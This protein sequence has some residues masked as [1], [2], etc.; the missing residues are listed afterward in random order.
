MRGDNSRAVS[1]IIPAKTIPQIIPTGMTSTLS[2]SNVYASSP[3]TD[4][5]NIGIA[6]HFPTVQSW[7][8]SLLRNR[9]LALAQGKAL[10]GS[11]A[12]S[13]TL[14]IKALCCFSSPLFD[15]LP[16]VDDTHWTSGLEIGE[17]EICD[18]LCGWSRW[19]RK[20]TEAWKEKNIQCKQSIAN[21]KY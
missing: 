2:S 18:S 10:I 20:K 12:L 1:L 3:S 4:T 21:F 6:S 13:T 9:L 8:S 11:A 15:E 16:N 14:E 19:P 17:S 5:A 7:S